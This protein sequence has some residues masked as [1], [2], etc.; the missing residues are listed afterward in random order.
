MNTQ[1]LNPE[2]F[3]CVSWLSGKHSADIE[4]NTHLPY[5]AIYDY[6][7]QGEQADEVI[8]EINHIYNT[9]D[10]TPLEACELWASYYL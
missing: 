7:A 5:V 10:C 3:T 8:K 4:I 9:K 2:N 6:F 1:T